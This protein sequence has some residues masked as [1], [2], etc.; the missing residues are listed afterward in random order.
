M[1]NI[2]KCFFL[3]KCV[4]PFGRKMATLHP[5]DGRRPNDLFLLSFK[6]FFKKIVYIPEK[7]YS[8]YCAVSIPSKIVKNFVFM[9]NSRHF[10]LVGA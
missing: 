1:K 7:T 10:V 9:K 3:Y 8:T 2:S 6:P 5:D 4:L